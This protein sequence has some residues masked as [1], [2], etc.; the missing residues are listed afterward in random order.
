MRMGSAGARAAVIKRN[1]MTAKQRDDA[2]LKKYG[3]VANRDNSKLMKYRKEQ[4]QN[5]NPDN[6]TVG[7][8]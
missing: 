7:M 1:K 6:F 3:L 5:P 2:E 4:M 8:A